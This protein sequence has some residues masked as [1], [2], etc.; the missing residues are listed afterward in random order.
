[1]DREAWQTTV[2]G[3]AKSRTQLS[4][5]TFQIPSYM[6]GK[7]LLLTCHFTFRWFKA[8]GHVGIYQL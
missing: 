6:C 3:V 4:D 8:C 5:N 2:H 7:Q 1:M